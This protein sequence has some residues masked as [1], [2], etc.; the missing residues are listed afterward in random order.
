MSIRQKLQ[1][2]E[3]TSSSWGVPYR[4]SVFGNPSYLCILGNSRTWKRCFWLKWLGRTIILMWKRRTKNRSCLR[5]HLDCMW[6]SCWLAPGACVG[7]FSSTYPIVFFLQFLV[8]CLHHRLAACIFDLSLPEDWK[9]EHLVGESESRC[10]VCIQ[11]FPVLSPCQMAAG[12][13][14]HNAKTDWFCTGN[15]YTEVIRVSV[16]GASPIGYQCLVHGSRT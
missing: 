3:R 16:F 4:L 9:L 10:L 14:T 2:P 6:R 1:F 8:E 5:H 12:L 13:Q 7:L 15:P 11:M